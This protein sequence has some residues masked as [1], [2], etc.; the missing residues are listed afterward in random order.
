M[1]LE[2]GITESGLSVLL[3]CKKIFVHAW[4]QDLEWHHESYKTGNLYSSVLTKNSKN[5]HILCLINAFS[6]D[7]GL[8][9]VAPLFKSP[10]LMVHNIHTWSK[11]LY[12]ML[13]FS[14]HVI[15]LSLKIAK[16][17]M[18]FKLR[19]KISYLIYLLCCEN[20]ILMAA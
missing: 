20:F 7:C 9:K 17:D 18:D 3:G 4:D 11:I 8:S 2:C 15:L 16:G 5:S 6:I 12:W 19:R 10:H 14:V 13:T 1:V